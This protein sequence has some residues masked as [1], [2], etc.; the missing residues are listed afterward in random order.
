[1][2]RRRVRIRRGIRT[3]IKGPWEDARSPYAGGGVQ[4]GA[5]WGACRCGQSEAAGRRASMGQGRA[6]RHGTSTPKHARRR[7]GKG[8][9]RASHERRAVER[10]L[11]PE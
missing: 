9:G 5:S 11:A 1:M 8:S 7:R 10:T 2:Q 4:H 6:R 3:T